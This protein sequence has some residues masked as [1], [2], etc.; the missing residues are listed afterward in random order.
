MAGAVFAHPVAAGSSVFDLGGDG[1]EDVLDVRPGGGIAAGHDGG[2]AARAL[3]AAGDAGAD[4][5]DA[6][7]G[8]IFGAAVGVG[9]E[10]VAAVDDDVAG[11][12]M[13]TDV[14]DDLVDGLAGLDHEHDAARAL[15]QAG[16]LLDGMRADDLGAL[17]F[18]GE[19]VVHLGDGAVE[20]G[21][22]EAVVVHVEDE[23]LAHDGQADE[24]DITHW[25]WHE[26]SQKMDFIIGA[27]RGG[28]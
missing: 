12:E 28:D 5:E 22:L 27:E 10:R 6:F 24:A 14:V 18:V 2:A 20:D 7:F 4:E 25:I 16:E 9:K 13:G 17:G 21:D 8:Q 19:E 15:E 26:G 3:F 1:L 23:V 11:F